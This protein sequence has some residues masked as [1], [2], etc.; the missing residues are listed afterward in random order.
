[1]SDLAGSSHSSAKSGE[2]NSIVSQDGFPE[3]GPRGQVTGDADAWARA[4]ANTRKQRPSRPVAELSRDLR[5]AADEL[6]RQ[7]EEVY[8]GTDEDGA[9]V[10]VQDSGEAPAGEYAQPF[11]QE[12]ADREAGVPRQYRQHANAKTATTDPNRVFDTTA[13]HYDQHGRLISHAD[14][15]AHCEKYDYVWRSI[16]KGERI[17]D[18]GCGT[19]TP[20]M[21]AINFVQSS[22]DKVRYVNGGCYVGV[23]LN[24]LKVTNINWAQL[25]GELDMTSEDGYFAALNAIPGNPEQLEAKF[26]DPR[27]YTML[28]CLEVIEH[29]SPEAGAQLLANMKDLMAPEGRIV[30]STPVYDGKGQA[31][32]HI[33]EYYVDEL[34]S[35]IQAAGLKVVR[36]MGTFTSEPQIKGWLRTTRPDW[37]ALYMEAREFH[38]SGYMS[39]LIAPMIPDLSRNNLWV[40]QHADTTEV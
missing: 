28:V 33:H 39:G 34:Q 26:G 37:Y 13:L 25:I 10:W 36:R 30:L 31:R 7:T 29:M 38:S 20:L 4:S 6:E 12:R 27:G 8:A 22:A 3:P 24:K 32:N 14:Y 17:L 18:V 16:A 15:I 19:D 2:E 1:M 21:R 5:D 35:A 40:L 23:D 11:S 9:D